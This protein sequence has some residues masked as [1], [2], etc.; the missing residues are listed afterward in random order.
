MNMERATLIAVLLSLLVTS[1]L[2]VQ[3]Q[4]T[5]GKLCLL[6]LISVHESITRLIA[7][8]FQLKFLLA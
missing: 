7:V 4:N 6:L 2:T 1:S 5:T 3:G 8:R